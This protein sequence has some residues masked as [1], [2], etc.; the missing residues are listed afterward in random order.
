MDQRTFLIVMLALSTGGC[1]G[2][3]SSLDPTGSEATRIANLYWWMVSG[4]VVLW[5]AVVAL[6]LYY[7]RPHPAAPSRTRDRFLIMG[8][9]IALPIV[10]LTALLAYGLAML[11]SLVAR[12]PEGSLR[13]QVVGEQWWWRVRYMTADGTIELANEIRLPVGEPVQFELA[14]D[15]VIHSFWIPSLGGKMDMI[16]GRTTY[17]ALHPQRTGVFAGACAEYCG[18]SHA[19]MRFLVQVLERDDFA[20]WLEHQATP[21]RGS[22]GPLAARGEEV[23]AASGCGACHTVRGT[24]ASGV[25]A[26]DLTHVG[27][28][29]SIG[30]GMLP[31]DQ[32]TVTRWVAD[33]ERIK[34]GVH[35]PPFHMLTS[36]DLEALGAYLAGLR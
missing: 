18:T 19:F 16:P 15:N 3:Q 20:E 34:P 5:L 27:G 21:A 8:A 1:A 10:V 17:L 11:P 33:P 23:F 36:G 22:E 9:G 12:A 35:M 32:S 29:L 26:P 24:T 13:V 28:R 4:A 7:G 14:S 25:I 6:G 2:I 31:A 30:A